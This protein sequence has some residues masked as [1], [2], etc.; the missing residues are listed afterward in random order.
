MSCTCGMHVWQP[1]VSIQHNSM[2]PCVYAAQV[3]A[4]LRPCVH[5]AGTLTE[6]VT[7]S[8]HPQAPCY[9]SPLRVQC[10]QPTL[11]AQPVAAQPVT[12]ACA[13]CHQGLW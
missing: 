8:Q 2:C 1:H 5:R 3:G 11:A 7:K 10:W 9:L 4:G 6:P 13:P 12:I